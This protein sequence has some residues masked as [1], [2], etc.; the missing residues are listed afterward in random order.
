MEL[1]QL[2]DFVAVAN[3][4]NF[5][6]AAKRCHVTQPALSRAIQR[7]EVEIGEQLFIRLKRRVIMT[8]G[9]NTLHQRAKRIIEEMEE[10]KRELSET[11]G[12]RRG[13]VSVGVLPTIAPYFLPRA[14][15]QFS[16]ACPSVEITIHEDITADLLQLVEACELDLALVSLPLDDKLF[17]SRFLF[18]EELLLAVP[19]KHPL[20]VKERVRLS[21]LEKERFILMKDGHCLGNQVLDLCNQNKL[22]L[23]LVL[24]SSQVETIHSLIIAGLGIS[25]VPQMAKISGRIPI[26]YRSLEKP[27]PSRTIVVIWRKERPLSRAAAEFLKHVEQAARAYLETISC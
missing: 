16:E 13:T 3:F 15:S 17:E 6:E 10:I 25:L 18:T 1:H 14:V 19:S 26:V 2:R 23:Q 7:L 9:G 27:K 12:L 11:N 24:R 22:R 21:D 4:G 5:H 8:P 20:A